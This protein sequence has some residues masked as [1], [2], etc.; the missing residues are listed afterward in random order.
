MNV[1]TVE[2]KKSGYGKFEY[3]TEMEMERENDVRKM[4]QGFRDVFYHEVPK[5]LFSISLSNA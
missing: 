3:E 2:G 4:Y 5:K 1:T